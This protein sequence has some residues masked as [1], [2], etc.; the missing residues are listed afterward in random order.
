MVQPGIKVKNRLRRSEAAASAQ[1][2]VADFVQAELYVKSL[3]LNNDS[4]R[5]PPSAQLPQWAATEDLQG[6]QDYCNSSCR[7]HRHPRVLAEWY[8]ELVFPWFSA[9]RV[10]C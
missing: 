5:A 10:G 1:C 6:Q 2:G 9:S 3:A 7:V 8:I 4:R